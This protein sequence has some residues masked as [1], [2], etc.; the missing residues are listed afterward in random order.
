MPRPKGTIKLDSLSWLTVTIGLTKETVQWYKSLP[1]GT[2]AKTLRECID[3]F[4]NQ[5]KPENS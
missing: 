3:L 2:K 4:R 1:E 5:N